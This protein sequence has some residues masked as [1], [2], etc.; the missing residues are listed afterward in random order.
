[1]NYLKQLNNMKEKELLRF[2]IDMTSL[3]W[4]FEF[5]KQPFNLT[6]KVSKD[7][8]QKES[9]LPYTDHCDAENIHKCFTYMIDQILMG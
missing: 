5:S 7:G 9:W 2:I 1:M 6:L 8:I 4:M 3:G